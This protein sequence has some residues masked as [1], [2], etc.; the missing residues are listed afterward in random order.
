MAASY[1]S[2][3]KEL[4]RGLFN[5]IIGK[6]ILFF[7]SFFNDIG[8]V[9]KQCLNLL[10]LKWKRVILPGLMDGFFQQTCLVPQANT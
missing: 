8:L 10:K 9:L 2:I 7:K 1:P 4:F 3:S 5:F 6:P